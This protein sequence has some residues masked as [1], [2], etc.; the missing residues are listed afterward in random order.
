SFTV[1]VETRANR[2]AKALV[3]LAGMCCAITRQTGSVGSRVDKICARAGGPPVEAPIATT[4]KRGVGGATKLRSRCAALDSAATILV[5]AL[6]LPGSQVGVAGENATGSAVEAR[7]NGGVTLGA[8]GGV[9][10][11]GRVRGLSVGGTLG[12]NPVRTGLAAAT[13][14]AP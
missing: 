1:K 10:R 5:E 9:W 12:T 8:D 13:K 11:A 2:V 7:S 4:R 14:A 6:T 3:N